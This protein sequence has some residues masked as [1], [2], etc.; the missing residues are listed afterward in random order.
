[1]K[2]FLKMLRPSVTEEIE[3]SKGHSSLRPLWTSIV[4]PIFER[5]ED[6]SIKFTIDVNYR[7]NFHFPRELI[8]NIEF[9]QRKGV[10]RIATMLQSSSS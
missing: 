9:P 5:L 7:T 3:T 8:Q 2:I 6:V 10:V 4:A 1:M